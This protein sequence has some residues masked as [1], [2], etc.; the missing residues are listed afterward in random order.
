MNTEV[1][2]KESDDSR[3]LINVI[4]VNIQSII[5]IILIRIIKSV[6]LLNIFFHFELIFIC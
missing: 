6:K 5:K 4:K 2:I 3:L 1:F